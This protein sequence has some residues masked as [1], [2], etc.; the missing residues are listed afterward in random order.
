MMIP[1]AIAP[2]FHFF[3]TYADDEHFVILNPSLLQGMLREEF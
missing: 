1:T 3:M 2:A